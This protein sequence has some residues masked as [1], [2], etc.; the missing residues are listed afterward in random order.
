MFFMI[1]MGANYLITEKT[2][3][4]EATYLGFLAFCLWSGV[5]AINNVYDVELDKK[6]D[7]KRAEYT[8]SLKS[9]IEFF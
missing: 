9:N 1:A 2:S 8:K 3:F 4:S 6:S 7:P 5:D